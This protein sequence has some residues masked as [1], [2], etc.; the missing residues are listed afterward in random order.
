MK[1]YELSYRKARGLTETFMDQLD[2]IHADNGP[3]TSDDMAAPLRARAYIGAQLVSFQYEDKEAKKVKTVMMI[4]P[5][6]DVK[7]ST[8]GLVVKLITVGFQ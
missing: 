8:V 1:Q 5:G 4:Q 6:D 7:L 3:K 2:K